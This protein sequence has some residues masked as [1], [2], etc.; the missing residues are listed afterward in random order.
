MAQ[1]QHLCT[2]NDRNG[3]PR[4][5]YVLVDD[6]Q[7]IAVWDEG[8]LGHH[9]VPGVWREDAYRAERVDIKPGLY[10]ELR[11]TLPSPDWAHDV[12]GYSHLL[13]LVS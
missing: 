2:H 8:Y 4:G 9:C 6:G 11:R 7:R 5:L 13:S 3:N 12:P 10:N 1:F